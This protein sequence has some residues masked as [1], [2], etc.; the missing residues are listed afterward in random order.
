M[1]Q[2][3]IV[4]LA[5][6]PGITSFSSLFTVK[7]AFN[8]TKVG[9]TGTLD[10]FASGLLV[11]CVGSLTRLAGKITE[12]NKSYEAVI[13]FGEETDT[14]EC[15][16]NIVKTAPLPTEENLFAAIKKNTGKLM[17]V[18]PTFSAIR[19]NGKRSSDLARK[20]QV[21]EI[22]PREIQVFSS[23]IKEILYDSEKKVSA[24]KIAFNVSKG[25]YIRSL[26]RDIAKD[27]GSVAYLVGLLR[28]KVGNFELKNAAGFKNLK[29][30]NIENAFI[31]AEKTKEKERI[32]QENKKNN[33]HTKKESSKE[34]ESEELFLEKEC[35]ACSVPMT[36]NL[37]LQCGFACLTLKNGKANLFEN[38][39]KLK[40]DM[41]TTSPFELKEQYAAV[42]T[43]SEDFKGLLEKNETGYFRYSFV[44]GK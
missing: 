33:I 5:K 11:V 20:G 43:E 44:V 30:F 34:F 31:E 35:V 8:T 27:C 37:A 25:T 22:K 7:R 39:A 29:E 38:G 36:K 19:V 18:P 10:S 3:R 32:I 26:A 9:H 2:N 15:I 17:Q 13:K 42:F 21:S 1:N 23:E 12:F 24:C 4:L 28:T 6:K 40:S 16:G 14:L 41:F